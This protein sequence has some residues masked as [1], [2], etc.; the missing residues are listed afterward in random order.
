[1]RTV[2]AVAAATLTL[3]AL[4][5]SAG[6][7]APNARRAAIATLQ[8]SSAQRADIHGIIVRDRHQ[9][10]PTVATQRAVMRVLT[11]DQQR[12]LAAIVDRLRERR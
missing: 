6:L 11:P 7:T 1:M 8:L 12:R 4:I 3:A 9:G 10:L 5:P 2:I